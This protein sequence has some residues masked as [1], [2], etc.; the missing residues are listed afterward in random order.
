MNASEDIRG[1]TI[2][3]LEYIISE[4]NDVFSEE[5]IEEIRYL[6][7]NDEYEMAFEVLMIESIKRKIGFDINTK[8]KILKIGLDLNLDKESVFDEFFW[9]KFIK[10]IEK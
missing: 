9:K 8:E 5:N 6:Y 3:I 10:L 4:Y 1:N 2:K 7:N